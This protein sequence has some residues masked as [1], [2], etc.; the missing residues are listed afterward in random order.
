LSRRQPAATRLGAPMPDALQVHPRRLAVGEACCATLAVTGYPREVG[1]GW[2][3]PL[4]T[5]PGRLDVALHVD[6]LPAVVATDRLRR[7]LAR[8]ESSRRQAA[9]VGRLADPAVDL[10]AG[11]ARRLGEKL[12]AGQARL[13]RV[14]LYVTVWADDPNALAG[15]V[16]RVR[17]VAAGLLLDLTV[18]V[19]RQFDGWSTTRP[20]GGDRLGLTR[21]MDTAGLAAGFPFTAPPAGAEAASP[22]AV[23]LGRPVDGPGLVFLDR[24]A[25]AA[26]NYNQVILARS[27]AGKSY[28]AKLQVLRHLYA[29]VEAFVVDPEDEYAR[30]VEFAGGLHV[31]LGAAGVRINPLDLNL[32]PPGPQALTARALATHTLLD[33]LLGGPLDPAERA[34]ADRGILAAYHA[35]GITA[36]P[37]SH[38]RP[39][40]TLP[41][42]GAQ[43]AADP[44]PV[45]RALSGRL[46]PFTAGSFCQLFDGPTSTGLSG[47]LVAVS[48]QGLPEELKAAGT[49]LALDGI[50]R[51]VA[52]PARRR[53]RLVVVDE[54]WLVAREAAGGAFLLRLAKSARKHWAGLTCITQD[55]A[56]LLDTPWGQSVV[57]NAASQV[58]LRQAPQ[59][60]PRLADAFG[61]TG[62]ERA[63]LAAARRGQALLATPAGRLPVLVHADP[64]EHAAITTDPAELATQ[65][66]G[67]R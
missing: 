17:A 45:G 31:P 48:L 1:P 40:P 14:G 7:Q 66:A 61:L 21:S 65:P 15:E 11:D 34:A 6:P 56:D 5:D 44:D 43:L 26:D 57:A 58:L 52:D 51:Q 23:F 25:P 35:A 9:G 13:F 18:T 37:R 22:T 10:A 3:T 38:R 62:G 41:D 39:A 12:A 16:A 46:T 19:F 2:L 32:E 27:G 49:A 30:L 59:A 50:W 29:G 42:V 8:L 28:L 47:H 20:L 63:F 64:V 4:L 60:L 53:P 54:A 55:A 24:F 36:D 67:G 33:L